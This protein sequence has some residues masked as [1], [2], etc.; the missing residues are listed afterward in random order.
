MDDLNRI[1]PSQEIFLEKLHSFLIT[2]KNPINASDFL[3]DLNVGIMELTR[4]V[5]FVLNTKRYAKGSTTAKIFNHLLKGNKIAYCD[6]VSDGE[7]KMFYWVH[8]KEQ[9]VDTAY[10]AD[11]FAF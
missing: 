3:N 5:Y 1:S 10:F 8:K 7:L 2:L 9:K 4:S 11:K 6:V